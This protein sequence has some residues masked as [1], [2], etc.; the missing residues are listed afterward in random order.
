MNKS[1]KTTISVITIML[2]LA[3]C[4]VFIAP[5]VQK[6]N[7]EIPFGQE[8]S[9]INDLTKQLGVSA[10]IFEAY[11]NSIDM[12]FEGYVKYLN[13]IQMTPAQLSADMRE[14]TGYSYSDYIQTMTLIGNKTIPDSTLYDKIATGGTSTSETA[15]VDVY[16][17]KVSRENLANSEI[18][19]SPTTLGDEQI[20]K[21]F[22]LYALLSYVNGDIP[23]FISGANGVFGCESVEITNINVYADY[24]VKAPNNKN[25]MI[26]DLFNVTESGEIYKAIA[27]PVLTLKFADESKNISFGVI[28]PAGLIFTANDIESLKKMGDIEFFDMH[29][30]QTRISDGAAVENAVNS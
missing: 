7:K 20:V 30:R 17:S 8:F 14:K 16:I 5:L 2:L 4:V 22:H 6:S 3:V 26:D 29:V 28:D 21:Y 18:T 9:D 24:G 27:M 25:A 10:E 23:A 12:D 11:L 1:K 13:S 15:E 19:M